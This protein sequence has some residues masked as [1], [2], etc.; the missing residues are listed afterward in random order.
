M[1][2]NSPR[3]D[4]PQGTDFQIWGLLRKVVSVC[5]LILERG[6]KAGEAARHPLTLRV[7]DAQTCELRIHYYVEGFH[8]SRQQLNM[9]IPLHL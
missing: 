2:P 3:S 5:R 4:G 9:L 1:K 8:L 6:L 7:S